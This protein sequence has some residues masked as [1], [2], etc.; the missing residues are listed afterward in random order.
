MELD[1]WGYVLLLVYIYL[2]YGLWA[3]QAV[4]HTEVSSLLPSLMIS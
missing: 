2:L 3:S 4:I 1:D